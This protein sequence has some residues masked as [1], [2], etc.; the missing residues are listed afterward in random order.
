MVVDLRELPPEY[1]VTIYYLQPFNIE[2]KTRWFDPGSVRGEWFDPCIPLPVTRH[3]R[4][5]RY[6]LSAGR[7]V[8]RESAYFLL[9]IRAPRGSSRRD[10]LIRVHVTSDGAGVA[11]FPPLAVRPFAF[12]LPN[13]HTLPLLAGIVPGDVFDLHRTYGLLPED[14][15]ELWLRY[16]AL[17]REHR[18]VPYDPSPEKQFTWE[19]F[20]SISLP[21]Y[22]GEL[23]PDG[24]PAPAIRF[25]R[26]RIDPG[27]PDGVAERT[28]FFRQIADRLGR[29]GMLDRS[30]YYV[31]DEPL[32][33][34]YTR[35]IADAQEIG[36]VVPEVRRLVTE[37]WNP[38]L[39]GLVD[40]W[41]PD[42]AML[43][44]PVPFFPLFGKGSGLQP[45][46][47]MNPD[48]DVYRSELEAGRE[49]WL[50]TCTSAQYA[51]LPNLFIDAPPAASRIIPWVVHR[52]HA[53]G[54]VYFRVTQ[55]YKKGNNPWKN[56]YYF[57][58]NGDGTLVYP[59]V[60]DFPWS[61]GHGV[62]ASLR[63]KLLRDGLEDYE[64]LVRRS[65][66]GGNAGDDISAELVPTTTSWEH[67]LS[68]I[69]AAR[70]AVGDNIAVAVQG[71]LP[72]GST[73]FN[74]VSQ[75]SLTFDYWYIPPFA[76]GNGAGGEPA[77]FLVP[78]YR[79]LLASSLDTGR[80]QA[81]VA[82]RGRWQAY[83]QIGPV[84]GLKGD[85]FQ[86]GG[87]SAIG[88]TVSPETARRLNR[89]WLIPYVGIEGGV[90]SGNDGSRTVTGFAGSILAGLHLWSTP[91]TSLSIGGAWTHTTTEAVPVAFR[92][93]V[94]FDFVLD[95]D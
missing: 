23:T 81:T 54:M 7:G 66:R 95:S 69:V 68:K 70:N 35:L 30:F 22:R 3:E 46:F 48:V 59:A 87:Y 74:Q 37:S 50:Y 43:N 28:A 40:I 61:D 63:M 80:R 92:G 6:D 77:S 25:P 38:Q 55:A 75:P 5:Q 1:D 51:D 62:V 91:R 17:L 45:D 4:V 49:L 89:N 73:S 41:C 15:G 58:A 88:W 76:I 78:S 93:S 13:E 85:T 53:T 14:E 18:I 67:D 31:D 65:D 72:R 94:S 16:L 33:G 12:D 71:D 57:N 83:L 20:E 82:T 39:A 56:Q 90:I 11:S 29:E 21:L 19:S 24:V 32:M 42:I 9:E 47:Q 52:Y 86:Y 79:H 26:N 44:Q 27:L 34:D 84:L 60:P 64:Y 36:A 10:G 8:D 2:R